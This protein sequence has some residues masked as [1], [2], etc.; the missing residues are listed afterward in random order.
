MFSWK[1]KIKIVHNFSCKILQID[2]R[3]AVSYIFQFRRINVSSYVSVGNY[4][5]EQFK[6][7]IL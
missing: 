1:K 7:R 5:L 3:E 2:L 6:L 4:M